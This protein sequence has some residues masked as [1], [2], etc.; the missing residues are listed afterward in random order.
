MPA[1]PIFVIENWLVI[2]DN[3][4]PAVYVCTA[5]NSINTSAVVPTVIG[6]GVCCT[7]EVLAL[8]VP[9]MTRKKS[10]WSI[11]STPEPAV[12]KSVALVRM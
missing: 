8:S 11:W 5:A 9:D 7:Q 1:V 3:P 10:P 12:S 6:S 2:R 4:V